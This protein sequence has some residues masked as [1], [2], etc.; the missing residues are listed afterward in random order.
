MFSKELIKEEEE[1]VIYK[2]RCKIIYYQATY[3][4]SDNLHKMATNK[5]NFLLQRTGCNEFQTIQFI[6]RSKG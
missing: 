4:V 6:F 3:V 5:I 2:T 1:N